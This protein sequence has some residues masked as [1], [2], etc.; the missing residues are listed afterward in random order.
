MDRDELL[1]YLFN[2]INK[3]WTTSEIAE[4]NSEYHFDAQS[5]TDLLAQEKRYKHISDWSM[6]NMDVQ[7]DK[8]IPHNE[9]ISDWYFAFQNY[10][11]G[12]EYKDREETYRHNLVQFYKNIDFSHLIG[13][14]VLVNETVESYRSDI[15]DFQS[16]GFIIGKS[17][18]IDSQDLTNH[19][20]MLR[21]KFFLPLK[22]SNGY[23]ILNQDIIDPLDEQAVKE[24]Q[25]LYGPKLTWRDRNYEVNHFKLDEI[26]PLY[27]IESLPTLSKE[28][29]EGDW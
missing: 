24:A 17:Y 14:W 27:D 4:L 28:D 9:A 5:F 25:N 11:K 3:K 22:C 18:F 8:L 13:T 19:H 10:K 12:Q 6:R 1:N 2:K 29:L 21:V 16:R 26:L 15:A 20:L 23:T 7:D